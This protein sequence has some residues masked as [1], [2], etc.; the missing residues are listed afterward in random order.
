MIIPKKDIQ[1]V[2][3]VACTIGEV[4]NGKLETRLS[5]LCTS[6][7][8]NIWSRSKP[9]I[10]SFT[11]RPSDWWKGSNKDCGIAIR[12]HSSAADLIASLLSGE[13][14]YSHNRPENNFRLGD[15]AGYHPT[16]Q[17]ALRDSPMSETL[18]Q[19]T[20]N[21]TASAIYKD[22]SYTDYEIPPADLYGSM[23]EWYF[24]IAFKRGT[25]VDWMTGG[26]A[27]NMSVTVPVNANKGR[28]FATGTIQA[29]K[30]ITRLKKTSF[31]GSTSGSSKFYAL[32]LGEVH[33]ITVKA[34][35]VE[36]YVT[37]TYDSG[38]VSYAV[39]LR[40]T[41]GS[42]V[43]I[44]QCSVQIT[45]RNGGTA[46]KIDIIAPPSFNLAANQTWTYDG[47]YENASLPQV[48]KALLYVNSELKDSTYYMVSAG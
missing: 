32:P 21:L 39:T 3:H 7:N 35:T 26:T 1:L 12:E 9:V 37:A 10:H 42:T 36:G 45:D 30:F 48:G 31:T 2:R 14:Q 47:T 43:A 16:V 5:K 40:N 24:G 19:S 38:V 18:Y 8:I 4:V 11:E 23:A 34:S 44:N 15:F 20:T 27:G 17:P 25:T 33:T 46:Y 29:A 6:D 28:I 41:S 22:G 13:S